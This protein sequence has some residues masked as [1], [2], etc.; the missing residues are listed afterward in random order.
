MQQ[1]DQSDRYISNGISSAAAD[2][3]D[4]VV[5]VDDDG[6]ISLVIYVLD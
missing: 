3:R 1:R 4:F 2:A 6:A 5:Y